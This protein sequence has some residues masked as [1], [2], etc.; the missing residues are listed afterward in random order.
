MGKI[1][2]D[3]MIVAMIIL[4]GGATLFLFVSMPVVFG[5][6]LYRKIRYGYKITD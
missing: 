1:L 3:I 4:G 2:M 5:W 6:K